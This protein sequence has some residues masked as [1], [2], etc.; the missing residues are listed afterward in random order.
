MRIHADFESIENCSF[1]IINKIHVVNMCAVCKSTEFNSQKG[2]DD[3]NK[4]IFQFQKTQIKEGIGKCLNF[5]LHNDDII[6]Q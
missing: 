1:L 2:K 3:D 5:H 6:K 4:T